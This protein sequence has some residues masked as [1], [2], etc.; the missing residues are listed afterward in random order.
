[1]PLLE[2][3]PGRLRP[4]KTRGPAT[5]RVPDAMAS[6]T[7]EPLRE[8]LVALLGPRKVL[9]A[10]S[11]LVKYASDASPYRFVPKA[12]AFVNSAGQAV[13]PDPERSAGQDK[14]VVTL[15]PG[16]GAWSALVYSNPA[17]TGVTTVVPAAVLVTP[18]GETEPIKV[19]W[20][21]GKVSNTG[22]ASVPQVSPFSPGDGG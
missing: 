3:D 21:G 20:A 16:A 12:V 11:D 4:P 22:K 18:P 19:P 6:G 15:A 9:H 10:P 8:D 14:R 1:M 5:D 17:V 13:T 7:P 2:P